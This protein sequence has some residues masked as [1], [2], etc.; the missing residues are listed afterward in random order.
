MPFLT[1]GQAEDVAFA[2]RRFSKPDGYGVLF[3]NGTGTGKAQPLDA[4]ILTPNGWVTMGDIKV[5]DNVMSVDGKPTKVL[6]VYPQGKKPIYR[7]TFNDGSST[8]SC[9]EHLWETQTLS[10]RRKATTNP[11]WNCAKPKIRN[12]AEIMDTIDAGHFIPMASPME[13]GGSADGLMIP[14]YTMG[15]L[16]GDGCFRATTVTISNPDPDIAARIYAELPESLTMIGYRD[17]G[18]CDRYSLVN[19][20]SANRSNGEFDNGDV[21]KELRRLGLTGTDSLLKFIPADYLYTSVDDRVALLQ[22]LLDTDGY[23]DKNNCTY[24]T[25]VSPTRS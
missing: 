13:F 22:G 10:E 4:G 11:E 24:Y 2:E 25:T 5:G 17:E 7:I 8:E 21:Q 15:A 12:L 23:A 6:G 1:D 18:K 14:P 3:T 20:E 19:T 16:L 9:D